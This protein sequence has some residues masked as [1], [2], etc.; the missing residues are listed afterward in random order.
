MLSES[1]ANFGKWAP[2]TARAMHEPTLPDWPVPLTLLGRPVLPRIVM[3]AVAEPRLSKH[4]ITAGRTAFIPAITWA[5]SSCCGSLLLLLLGERR[6]LLS[7]REPR[8][9]LSREDEALVASLAAAGGLAA[10]A[11]ATG[12]AGS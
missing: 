7:F 6:L 4:A 12:T 10:S 1:A 8:P 9:S 3:L 11:A 2:R 5:R